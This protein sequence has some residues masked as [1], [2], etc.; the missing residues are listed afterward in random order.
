[1]AKKD[2]KAGRADGETA[3]SGEVATEARPGAP[4]KGA[5]PAA[6][7]KA[8]PPAPRVAPKLAPQAALLPPDVVEQT[9]LS[10]LE[11][12]R[13]NWQVLA[14]GSLVLIV[15]VLFANWRIESARA[16]NRLAQQELRQA[17]LDAGEGG[18]KRERLEELATTY[19]GTSA[20]PFMLLAIGDLEMQKGERAATERAVAAYERVIK[21]HASNPVAAGI[22]E[23]ALDAA[24]KALAFDAKKRAEE[25]GE[26]TEWAAGEGPPAPK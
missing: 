24:K 23:R 22:A 20:V 19:A 16:R 12:L 4:E 25:R 10:Y 2:A 8:E 18:P 13:E 15:V 5:E 1:M 11:R 7:G 17:F 21:E 6:P 26:K 9:A 3:R 14:A